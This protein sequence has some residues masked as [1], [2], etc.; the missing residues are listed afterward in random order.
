MNK[1]DMVLTDSLSNQLCTENIWTDWTGFL[2]AERLERWDI[3]CI[4]VKVIGYCY[5]LALKERV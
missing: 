4:K 3:S 1:D 2:M 5:R